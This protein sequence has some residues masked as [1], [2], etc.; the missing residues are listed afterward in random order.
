[1]EAK[2]QKEHEWLQ[3][4]VGEWT[5]ESECR[6]GPDKLPESFTGSEVVRSIGGLWIVCEGQGEMPDGGHATTIMT[7]GFDPA[8]QRYL[9]TFI[10]SMMANLW[11]YEGALDANGTTLPLNSEGPSFTDPTKTAKYRDVIE[12]KSA[13]HRVMTSHVL[14][15]DGKWTSFMTANYRRK[16]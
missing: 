9:G 15:G 13:N 2:P 4:L 12:I 8:K 1:M 14:G 10:G 5:C 16:T 11:L 3:Q 7:L 6:M